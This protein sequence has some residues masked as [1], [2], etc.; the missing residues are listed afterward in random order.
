MKGSR[1][2]VGWFPEAGGLKDIQARGGM[3]H[4]LLASTDDRWRTSSILP[5]RI[6]SVYIGGIMYDE[7]T[8]INLR[9]S[10]ST[11]TTKTRTDYTELTVVTN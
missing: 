3:A 4:L 5:V 7:T 8:Q 1:L 9:G 6:R 11:T 10:S 2:V